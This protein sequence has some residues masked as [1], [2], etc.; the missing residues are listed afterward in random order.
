MPVNASASS[1]VSFMNNGV[2][3]PPS[4]K[5]AQQLSQLSSQEQQQ[6]VGFFADEEQTAAQAEVEATRR[7]LGDT[8]DECVALFLGQV[9]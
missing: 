3:L 6:G 7:A 2:A 5:V 9:R 8:V 1:T 4:Q